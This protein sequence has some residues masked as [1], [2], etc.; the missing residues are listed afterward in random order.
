MHSRL[1]DGSDERLAKLAKTGNEAAAEILIR[2]YSD[3]I[4]R[5]SR[6]Y[7]IMGADEEDVIQE[8]MIGLMK[9]IRSYATDRGAS[10]RT[11]AERCITGQILDAVKAAARKKHAPLN[12]SVSLSKPINREEGETMED[13][14]QAPSASDSKM[15]MILSDV[16]EYVGQNRE[17]VFSDLEVD[18]W[19]LYM[20]G[21]SYEEIGQTLAREKKSIYNAMERTRKKVLLY[22]GE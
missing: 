14:L 12:Q 7:F 13:L 2:R 3:T 16:M 15:A 22:L 18:V 6:S 19:N 17:K 20:E 1:Q 4:R 21:K 8:A 11:Y 5:K 10:F 9:A